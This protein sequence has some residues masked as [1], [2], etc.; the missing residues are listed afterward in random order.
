MLNP[1]E[2][3][4]GHNIQ[5]N[6][7]NN[8]LAIMLGFGAQSYSFFPLIDIPGIGSFHDGGLQDNLGANLAHRL[9]Q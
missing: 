9:S 4:S 8:L 2:A 1:I 3:G 6:A 7:S 5:Y